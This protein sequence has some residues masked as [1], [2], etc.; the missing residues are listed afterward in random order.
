MKYISSLFLLILMSCSMGVV[1]EG[2][3]RVY[4]YDVFRDYTS[5]ELARQAPQVVTTEHRDP[6][7]GKLEDL[8]S[9][10]HPPLKRVGILTFETIIQ[11][12]RSGLTNFDKIYLSAQGKQLLT[13]KMLSIW[14]QSFPILGTDIEYVPVSKIKKSRALKSWGQEVDDQIKA[15]RTQL[16]PDDIFF[17]PSGKEV[18]MLTTLNARG[19]RD[20][21]LALVPAYEMM[22]GP[23]FSEH[24]KHAVN[25]VCKELKLDAVMIVMSEVSWSAAR[26]D[27]HSQEALPEEA[28]IE[29]QATTLVPLSS[30]HKR[31]EKLGHKRN[32]HNINVAYRA[33]ESKL[34]I[35]INISVPVEQQTFE[36]IESNLL[37]PMLKTY[38]D[39][40]HMVQLRIIEDLKKTH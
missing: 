13:E 2:G 20:L 22:H 39:L 7:D 29:I 37:T 26:I 31:L 33:Y 40:S 8:F 12:A 6:I 14:D 15:K 11:P 17:M 25:E 35:P 23:K 32:L 16:M 10:K 34:Q 30:Y 38:N 24:M 3:E 36:L 27:K 4:T 21:S 19:M 18:T 1:K 9:K 28:K 5:E